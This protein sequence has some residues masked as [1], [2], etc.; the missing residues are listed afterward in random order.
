MLY[1]SILLIFTGIVILVYSLFHKSERV[2]GRVV[3]GS[4]EPFASEEPVPVSKP[5]PSAEPARKVERIF[6]EEAGEEERL[7][8]Q[9]TG[10]LPEI[11]FDS[12]PD[13]EDGHVEEPNAD[14]GIIGVVPAVE[15]DRETA[16]TA[17]NTAGKKRTENG[18]S[19]YPELPDVTLFDDRSGKMNYGD[20]GMSIRENTLSFNEIKRVGSGVFE[21]ERQGINF[22]K[23][24]KFFRFDFHRIDTLQRGE[25]FI[26][27]S[28][29]GSG[30]VKLFL[31]NNS[32]SYI[33]RVEEEFR[34]YQEG[35]Q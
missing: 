18:E 34:K 20:P 3:T 30:P 29:K 4:P 13:G 6:D 28:L 22:R 8:R 14:D 11:D 12:F 15:D 16:E 19:R 31:F 9:F 32:F 1:I 35:K 33:D 17:I 23:N 26:A 10:E 7:D 24:N 2:Q 21:L 25:R 5:G 27:L